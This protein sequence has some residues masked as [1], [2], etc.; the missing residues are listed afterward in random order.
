M[1]LTPRGLRCATSLLSN[2]LPTRL[3]HLFYRQ[4]LRISA[5]RLDTDL[6]SRGR[7]EYARLLDSSQSQ[8]YQALTARYGSRT[9]AKLLALKLT[10][11]AAGRYQLARREA[12]LFSY[13]VLLM[14]DPTNACQ[15]GCPG[16][17]HS[18]NVSYRSLF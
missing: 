3:L 12:T 10:N 2:L 15:L 9:F 7:R 5:A 13:P 8:S 16:C 6:V 18:S 4:C 17:V 11:L 1:N 14:V